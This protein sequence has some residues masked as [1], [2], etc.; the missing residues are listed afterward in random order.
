[1][2]FLI[3]N[4]ERSNIYIRYILEIMYVYIRIYILE[5]MHVL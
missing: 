1:M 4:T 2:I 5:I 3:C